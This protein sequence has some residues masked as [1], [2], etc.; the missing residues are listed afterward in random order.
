VSLP[1][2]HGGEAPSEYRFYRR[3]ISDAA[4]QV[5]DVVA[6]GQVTLWRPSWR[7]VPPPLLRSR[8]N[9]VWWLL[10]NLHVFRSRAFCVILVSREGRLVHR[11]S[12]FPP[13]FRFPFMRPADV[14]IGDTWTDEAERG[15][16]LATAVIGVALTLPARPD[17][18]A[19]YVVEEHNRASIRAV[20]KAG[21]ALV[22]RGER[23]PR[24]GLRALGYYAITEPCIPS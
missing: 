22:G 21:F 10:H 7:R 4:R 2:K 3:S 16:G 5:S 20:E 12:V 18:H 17:A 9:W 6:A 24:L 8:V 15:R 1:H 13:Y 19:W 11:S 23:R 14:Q